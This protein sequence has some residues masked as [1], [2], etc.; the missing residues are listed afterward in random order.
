ML[1]N[2][3]LPIAKHRSRASDDVGEEACPCHVRVQVRVWYRSEVRVLMSCFDNIRGCS[4]RGRSGN[5]Q[6]GLPIK[7]CFWINGIVQLGVLF[8]LL[9]SDLH[10]KGEREV[11]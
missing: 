8:E 9:L 1:P 3:L 4:R 11:L 10:F 7:T 2:C 5:L 6:W